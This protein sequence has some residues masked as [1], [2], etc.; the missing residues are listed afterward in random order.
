[1]LIHCDRRVPGARRR[2]LSSMPKLG[3]A[4]AQS[5]PR[6]SKGPARRCYLPVLTGLA[7]FR[8]AGP[9]RSTPPM[10]TEREG[11][12]PS[13]R[14]RRLHAFQACLFNHSSTSPRGTK[15]ADL[16]GRP[17]RFPEATNSSRAC[18]FLAQA[19]SVGGQA[20]LAH[21][22]ERCS[23][24]YNKGWPLFAW[25]HQNAGGEGGI[26]TPERFLAVTRFRG[27]RDQPTLP[28]LRTQD[29]V[30]ARGRPRASL[31]RM[32]SASPMLRLARS[33]FRP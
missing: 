24:Y 4:R 11:F 12:E 30:K 13:R 29:I 33:P 31:G 14:F 7:G 17:L 1:M 19:V 6:H 25:L 22:G 21:L 23:P 16:R 27:E 32:P 20:S 26:R 3:E 18:A 10:R 8:R 9:G 5:F 2:S 28:P 15:A